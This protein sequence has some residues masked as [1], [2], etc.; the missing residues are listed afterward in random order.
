MRDGHDD[1][2]VARIDIH[3][4]R[5]ATFAD[6][7]LV[8]LGQGQARRCE[9]RVTADALASRLVMPEDRDACAAG[10]VRQRRGVV[11]QQELVP[12]EPRCIP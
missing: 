1:G 4:A 3:V 11:S 8:G 9:R 6:A 7:L 10:V 5:Y 2:V 12:D